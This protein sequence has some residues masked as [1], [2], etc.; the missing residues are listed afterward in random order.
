M[1]RRNDRIPRLNRAVIPVCTP[2]CCPP[3]ARLGYLS[4]G[5]YKCPLFNVVWLKLSSFTSS[6]TVS[7]HSVPVLHQMTSVLLH[8][9]IFCRAWPILMLQYFK[10]VHQTTTCL[11]PLF[12]PNPNLNAASTDDTIRPGN[13][14]G[15]RYPD[16]P[17]CCEAPFFGSPVMSAL[18][19]HRARRSVSAEKDT[20][21]EAY[22]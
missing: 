15:A 9:A 5:Y 6:R 3:A 17:D 4:T 21:Y 22:H 19:S 1:Y 18:P 2:L 16:D 10:Q 7:H 13:Q 14:K 20:C 12:V 11:A 8:S